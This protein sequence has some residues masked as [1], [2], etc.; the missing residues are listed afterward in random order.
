MVGGEIT[1]EDL[2]KFARVGAKRDR[3]PIEIE[4]ATFDK[5]TIKD[6]AGKVL[7]A[8]YGSFHGETFESFIK[9]TAKA[10]KERA[11]RGEPD[12]SPSR[13]DMTS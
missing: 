10:L 12:P 7:D 8:L 11:D 9:R 13:P 5:I 1:I 6:L 4:D 2:E 3:K